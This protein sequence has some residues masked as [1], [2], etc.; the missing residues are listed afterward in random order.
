[1]ARKNASMTNELPV[2]RISNVKP[3]EQWLAAHHNNT[4]GAWVQIAKKSSGLAT[5]THDQVLDVA[6]CYGW[7]DSLRRGFDETYFLQKFTP[8]RPKSP[9]SARNI[10]KVKLLQAAGKMQPAGL[11]E[12]KAAIADGR[13][14]DTAV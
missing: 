4:N 8:R 9:W 2:I 1:M 12:I 3:W 5:V 14:I 7:I 13:I 11:A 6:L 10:E